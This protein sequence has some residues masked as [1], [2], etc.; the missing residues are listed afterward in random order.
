MRYVL[1]ISLLLILAGCNSAGV[2]CFKPAGALETV[3]Y[4]LPDFT[5]IE[6]NSNIE[7]RLSMSARNRV[8]LTAGSNLVPGIKVE[9]IDGVLYLDNLNTCNWTRDYVNPV[10]E[11]SN[12]GINKIVQYG[13]GSIISTDSLAYEKL[14]L[15]CDG[16]SGDFKLMVDVG[17]LVVVTN[18][19]ANFYISGVAEKLAVGIYYSDGIFYGENL[20]AKNCSITHR[21]SNTIHLN[22]T[23]QLTGGI[24]SFGDVIAHK[25]MPLSVDIEETGTGRFIYEP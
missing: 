17:S 6:V 18:N 11:I 15:E 1:V 19:V 21:G 25:Q 5:T 20:V 14:I 13:Y 7:V 2:G 23:G 12:P 9:V 8:A 10:I 3:T 22:L 16:G 24:Y 4:D